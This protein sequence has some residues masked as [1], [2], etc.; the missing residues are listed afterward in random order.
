MKAN[1]MHSSTVLTNSSDRIT[2]V[3]LTGGPCAGKTTL[4]EK[5][6]NE[7]AN[8]PNIKVFFAK[9]AA[10]FLKQSGINFN[11]AGGDDT[12][13]R[14]IVEQQ[15]IAEHNARVTAEKFAANHENY[16]VIIVCDRGIMDGEAYFKEKHEFAELLADYEL[17]KK[18]VYKR[19]DMILFLRSAA[20]GAPEF[21]TTMDGTPRDETPELAISLDSGVYNAWCRHP[22]FHAIENSFKFYEKLDIAVRLILEAAGIQ[23]PNKFFKRFLIKAPNLLRLLD[24]HNTVTIKEQIFFLESE[25]DSTVYYTRIQRKGNEVRYSKREVR[26]GNVDNN[27]QT[28]FTRIFEQDN[29]LTEDEFLKELARLNPAILPLHR[30][31][32]TFTSGF[33]VRCELEI[34][35]LVQDKMILKVY[36]DSENDYEFISSRYQILKDVTN[37]M[38]YSTLEIAKS[39]CNV[40]NS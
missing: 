1:E 25:D 20:V 24:E 39:A 16:K 31:L 18:T 9:E 21:Y 5:F 37:D 40:L 38:N 8:I 22:N 27:G 11:D 28:V 2:T 13:Q 3:V 10:T 14:L 29:T 6:R 23:A 17:T 32:F 33:S 36:M 19:Y 12:F 26:L 7:V 30:T 35:P 15:L 34:Y 4:M